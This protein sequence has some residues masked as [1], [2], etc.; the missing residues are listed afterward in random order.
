MNKSKRKNILIISTILILILIFFVARSVQFYNE[1]MQN[2][3]ISSNLANF[4]VNYLYQSYVSAEP[5]INDRPYYGAD[6][7]EITMTGYLD[8]KS[9]S[10]KYFYLYIFPKIDDEYI[11][12]GRLKFYAKYYLT[13]EDINE[14][15]EKFMSALYIECTKKIN[16][17][18]YNFY[19]DLINKG[20]QAVLI[21]YNLTNND[22]FQKC[23]KISEPAALFIDVSEVQ[24]FGML[25]MNPRFYMGLEG[26]SNIILEG[27]PSYSIFNHTIRQQKF[28]IGS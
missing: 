14:K 26:K 5:N 21:L 15:N 6:G 25:G 2:P 17:S 27:V 19:F 23:I 9:N 10:S 22:E 4:N 3:I 24:N 7:A 12:T 20:N 16:V 18:Y 13:K 28:L 8:L 1:E 11:K